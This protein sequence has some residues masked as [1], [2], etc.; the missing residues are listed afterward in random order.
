M[1]L[2]RTRRKL[3]LRLKNRFRMLRWKMWSSIKTR[4]NLRKDCLFRI[5]KA[6]T[7]RPMWLK[8]TN[9][10]L[11]HKL[12]RPNLSYVRDLSQ[13]ISLRMKSNTGWIL[14]QLANAWGSTIKSTLSGTRGLKISPKELLLRIKKKMSLLPN[15]STN[16]A[17][18]TTKVRWA[19][20]L[21]NK[22]EY[23]TELEKSLINISHYMT[24]DE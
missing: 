5:I 17:L 6:T 24:F 9:Q 7:M 2:L 23:E 4:P 21:K 10:S 12:L 1:T 16:R 14:L 15:R 22:N 18:T 11:K 8:R 19:R 3:H 13:R 20:L